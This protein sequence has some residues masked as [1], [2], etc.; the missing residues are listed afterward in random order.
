MPLAVDLSAL[1][2]SPINTVPVQNFATTTAED[3]ITFTVGVVPRSIVLSNTNAWAYSAGPT[4][5]LATKFPVAANTP[6]TL[7][8]LPSV[9]TVLR[10]MNQAVSGVMSGAVVQ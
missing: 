6:V 9:I 3:T 5:A 1:N 4:G 7:F 10:V 2:P 8:L